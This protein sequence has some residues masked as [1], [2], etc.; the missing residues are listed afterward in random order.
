MPTEDSIVFQKVPMYRIGSINHLSEQLAQAAGKGNR[1]HLFPALVFQQQF[2][3]S[4]PAVSVCQWWVHGSSQL[5][6]V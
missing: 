6:C 2:P 3:L 4:M 1:L 5:P